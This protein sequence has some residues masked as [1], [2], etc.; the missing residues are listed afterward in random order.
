[1]QP[2]RKQ[3]SGK[4]FI[5]KLFTVGT[6]FCLN[7]EISPH[8][9]F[10]ITNH[11]VNSLKPLD[12]LFYNCESEKVSFIFYLFRIFFLIENSRELK[13]SR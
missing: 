11:F 5:I 1:M 2:K 10:S 13:I 6:R 4:N 12:I 8:G 3:A 7:K 9:I